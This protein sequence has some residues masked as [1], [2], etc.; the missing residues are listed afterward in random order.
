MSSTSSQ[1]L[2][3]LRTI[4][5]IVPSLT[6]CYKSIHSNF[7]YQRSITRLIISW[8]Y[9][10]WRG[11]ENDW[12]CC[13][14]KIENDRIIEIRQEIQRLQDI[15]CDAIAHRQEDLL[16][17]KRFVAAEPVIFIHIRHIPYK[18]AMCNVNAAEWSK[19]TDSEINELKQL[20]TWKEVNIFP[21]IAGW[22]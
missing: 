7:F 22:S 1:S 18:T 19:A 21:H 12:C 4:L 3:T 16:F 13:D 17:A 5:E 2:A 15:A 6:Q 14:A 11:N 8:G 10:H 9:S 20:K